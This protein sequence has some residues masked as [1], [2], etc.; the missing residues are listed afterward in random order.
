MA[1][2]TGY[3]PPL[4]AA[5]SPDGFRDCPLAIVAMGCRLPGAHDLAAFWDLLR[6]GRCSL[7]ELPPE[8]LD[9]ELYFAEAKGIA[10]KT[11]SRIGGYVPEA[12]VDR[13]Y[14]PISDQVLETADP[15]HLTMVQVVAETIRHGGI[16]PESLRG[17]RAGVFIGH[18]RGSRVAGEY[19]DAI[20]VEDTVR[21][22]ETLPAFTSLP[23]AQRRQLADEVIRRIREARPRRV[24]GKW[25]RLEANRV[26]GIVSDT[27]GLNG[28]SL[29][30]DAACASSLLALSLAANALHRGV[31]DQAIVGGASHS[32]WFSL[33]MFSQAQALSAAGSFPFDSRAD[34]FISSDGFGAIIVKPLARALAEGNRIFG[35]IR[36]I[37]VATDGRGKSL[38]APRKE[39]QIAAIERAYSAGIDPASVQYVEAHGTS[40][41]LG[42]ATELE[43]LALQLGRHFP[44]GRRVP[45]S[46]VKANI[47]HTRETAGIAGLIKTLLCM[48]HGRIPGARY[49]QTLNP[50]IPWDKVP[51]FVPIEDVEWPAMNGMPRRAGIDAFGIGGLNAHVIVDDEPQTKSGASTLS[52][53]QSSRSGSNGAPQPERSSNGVPAGPPGPDSDAVAIISVG[54]VA[55]GSRTLADFNRLVDSGA[56]P[57]NDVPPERWDWRMFYAPGPFQNWRSPLKRAGFIRDFEY[58]WKRSRIPP[59]QVERADPLQFMVLDAAE[60][61]LR[62]AGQPARDWPRE[63]MGVVV[64]TAFGGDFSVELNRVLR[65][66]EF[67]RT[68]TA[69][70][71]QADVP[72]AAIRKIC[73]ELVEAFHKRHPVLEDETG[74][75]TSST[76]SSRISKTLDLMGG[77]YSVDSGAASSFAALA[78]AVDRLLLGQNDHVICAAGQRTLDVSACEWLATG[79]FLETAEEAGSQGAPVTGLVPGEAAAALLLKRLADAKRDGDPILA[80]IRGY[81]VAGHQSDHRS[82]VAQAMRQALDKAGIAPAVPQLIEAAATGVPRIDGAEAAA[83]SEVFGDGRIAPLT[84]GT[85]AQQFGFCHGAAG[86]LSLAKVLHVFDARKLPRNFSGQTALADSLRGHPEARWAD[87]SGTLEF[88]SSNGGPIAGVTCCSLEP[89]AYHVVLEHPVCVRQERE[90][91]PSPSGAVILRLGASSLDDLR[92]LVSRSEAFVEEAANGPA[93]SFTEQD[94]VRFAAVADSVKSLK[95]KLRLAGEKL[96]DQAARRALEEQG[97]FLGE[98][99]GRPARVAVVFSGQGSQYAGMFRELVEQHRPAALAVAEIDRAL[100]AAGVPRFAALAWDAEKTGTDVLAT[101]LAVLTGD[102]LAFEVL[103]SLGFRPDVISAHSYGEYAALVAAGCWSLGTAV[104]ATVARSRA[105]ENCDSARGLMLSTTAPGPVAEQICRES[106]GEVFVANLNA[107]DQTVLGGTPQAVAAAAARLQGAGFVTREIPVPRPFHTPLM[108]AVRD[109]LR[110]ALDKLPIHPPRVPFLSSVT[111]RYTADPADIRENLVEQLV[112]PVRYVELVERLVAEDVAVFVEAG[113][114]QVLTRLTRGIIGARPVAAVSFD[115]P[116]RPG[117]ESLLRARAAL[118]CAGFSFDSGRPA[119]T[120]AGRIPAPAQEREFTADIVHFDA[121][122][123]RREKMRNGSV[124]APSPAVTEAQATAPA[125]QDPETDELRS[126]LV[127]FIC[128]Q[129][130]YPPQI[131]GLDADLEADLGIDSIKKAQMLGELREMYEFQPARDLT[132]AAFPT[133]RHIVEFLKGKPR[134]APSAPAASGPTET[135]RPASLEAG[136]LAAP[137]ASVANEPGAQPAM[138]PSDGARTDAPASLATAPVPPTVWNELNVAHFAGSP[139]EMGRQHGAKESAIIGR[140]IASYAGHIAGRNRVF[141]EIKYALSHRDEF[142]DAA[143]LEELTGMAETAGIGETELIVYNFGLCYDFVPGCSQFAVAARRNNGH[144][145]VHAVNE[146]WTLALLFPGQL[147]RLVQVRFPEGGVPHVLFGTCGQVGGLNGF[148]A[149]GLCLSSTLLMDRMRSERPQPGL[150]HPVL[151]RTVL[152]RATSLEE[153]I[154]ICRSARRSGA[155]SLCLSDSRTDRIRHIE[156]DADD[157]RVQEC[158]AELMASTNHGLLN[159]PAAG[160]P[161]HSV[162]RFKRL[163]ELLAGNGHCPEYSAEFAQSVLA[164]LYDSGRRRKVKH[165][166]MSTIRRVDTQASIVMLPG[167]NKVRIAH[168]HDAP[169]PGNDFLELDMNELFKLP[170]SNGV[171]HLMSRFVMRTVDSPLPRTLPALRQSLEKVAILGE[172]AL[173]AEL[174]RQ[175]LAAGLSATVV[176][177]SGTAEQV[178]AEFNKLLAGAPVRTLVLLADREPRTPAGGPDQPYSAES[179]PGTLLPFRICQRWLRAAAEARETD[180]LTIV[181]V[182]AMSGDFGFQSAP[183]RSAG[184]ALCGLVKAIRREFPQVAG[185]VID[186]PAEEPL[187][188]VATRLLEELSSGNADVEVACVRGKRR[189]VRMAPRP[190]GS[191][192]P[193]GAL[194]SGVWIATGGARGV[195]ARMALAL[196]REFCLTLHLVG[197]SP[198]PDVAAEWLAAGERELKQHRQDLARAAR[199]AG[200]NPADEWREFERALEITRNLEAFEAAGVR[201]VYHS[202]DIA[203]RQALARVLESIRSSGGP[204]R[205]VLHGAG[206]ESAS[207]LD[208]KKLAS[209]QATIAAKVDGAAQLI[210][211]TRD[212]PLEHFIAF[213]SVSGR[214]GGVGQADYSLASDMLAKLVSRLRGSRPGL[215]ATTFHWPAWDEVGMAM[216]PES[217]VVLEAAGHRFMPLREGTE[218]LIAELRAGC[219]EAEVLI[220]DRRRGFDA[221][222]ALAGERTCQEYRRLQNRANQAPMI[223]GIDYLVPGK[224]LIAGLRFDPCRDRFLIEHQHMGIPIL[225]AVVGL[226]AVAESATIL[227]DSRFPMELRDVHMVNGFRFHRPVPANA[228]VYVEREGGAFR[229][230]LRGEFFNREGRLTDSDRPYLRARVVPGAG[231]T[232]A[233]PEIP[234]PPA[235]WWDMQYPTPE[236]AR[237]KGWVVHGPAFRCMRQ[238]T[239]RGEECWG[240]LVLPAPGIL[241]GDRPGSGEWVLPSVA[242]D[243]CMQACGALLIRSRGVG[244]LPDKFDRVVIG[245]LPREGEPAIVYARLRE[246]VDRHTRFDIVMTGEGGDLLLMVEGYRG[247]MPIGKEQRRD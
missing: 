30:I 35:V 236:R 111:N 77:A 127:N 131:V 208:R 209:V 49:L 218:H 93:R 45:V 202:C 145:L 203:D 55:P 135:A 62:G 138:T 56:D 65:M 117:M 16:D 197:T 100:E 53:P 187:Q 224:S 83:I 175:F 220:A 162:H 234:P 201:A 29:A 43:A 188:L 84:V 124:A 144:G 152:E 198:M 89:L 69:V 27:Y 244:E 194:P 24:A 204:I 178:L 134:R 9:Q 36:G 174:Q 210:E 75:Y 85:L 246:I 97:L 108:A 121:T 128:E 64:G 191:K 171:E 226:E 91:T 133:L 167:A 221:G 125:A 130:G 122:A 169:S 11:Y 177:T 157:F 185:K 17:S 3:Q 154:E 71:R 146:D 4:G 151:V 163:R 66:P 76:L 46:S 245:R 193:T 73:D 40:T 150:I 13:D 147:K 74:S 241:G 92:G 113:P 86:L 79:G 214:F 8:R 103:R 242:L 231:A 98:T 179:A 205:G 247:I 143:G 164:D 102:Y 61:A 182:T 161:E 132:L 120:T 15:V 48:Q 26:A 139:R 225:P 112:R 32:N 18:A 168:P 42:D 223:E 118:E 82:A 2:D 153:A 215:R 148:N 57:K 12:A 219:P 155:W 38:W 166:T 230:E 1:F 72:E 184:G 129:T 60:Q 140:M 22:L 158:D 206:V 63:R 104:Q 54:L 186:S 114:R 90:R 58:D 67:L 59:K 80:V 212:D 195:T 25:M 126:F 229:C 190:A 222:D 227:A 6:E 192:V 213:G 189:V 105:I 142:I 23:E 7:G 228:R 123:T 136:S 44:P 87:G 88:G 160:I 240:R 237:Q 10:G 207:R 52:A 137:P 196:G 101:Q 180:P 94:R 95:E 41:Q 110:A 183:L 238:V 173:A 37:G 51:F 115:N 172:G 106:E 78:C 31:I 141:D 81:G 243:G 116:K 239:V 199:E 19:A 14:C 156:Y 159:E 33:V 39:G 20:H 50:L 165:A 99:N 216:R 107:P 232:V 70:A 217:R 47:G 235:Q 181:A 21:L 5:T 200:R 149:A 96:V 28:P 119:P 211:L 109:E 68:L 176:S 34:G 233:A 170:G